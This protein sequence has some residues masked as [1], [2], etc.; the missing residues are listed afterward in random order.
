MAGVVPRRRRRNRLDQAQRGRF[1]G[2]GPWRQLKPSVFLKDRGG[3][4][5]VQL[6]PDHT[7][8]KG[9]MVA[10]DVCVCRAFHGPRPLGHV[11]L[12][13][14]DPDPANCRADNLRWAR[15]EQDNSAST[16]GRETRGS[17]S[18]QPEAIALV[19]PTIRS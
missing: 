11:P 10:V 12:H 6:L 17:S 18:R 16:H 19:L 14:P 1:G 5:K 9:R 8:R 4:L 13:W 15:A 2:I 3:T 7:K